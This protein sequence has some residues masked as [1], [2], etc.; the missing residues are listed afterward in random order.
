MMSQFKIQ[1]TCYSCSLITQHTKV[2]GSNSSK[3]Q[4]VGRFYC[5]VNGIVCVTVIAFLGLME[6]ASVLW[7]HPR[8]MLFMT[9]NFHDATN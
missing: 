3:K 1:I 4:N 2:S 8:E 7:V 9:L 5:G 6:F